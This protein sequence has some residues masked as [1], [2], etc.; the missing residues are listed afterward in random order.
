MTELVAHR[1]VR[2]RAAPSPTGAA[3]VGNAYIALFNLAFA[4]RHGG[5]FVMRIE[6]TDRARSRKKYEERLYAGWRWLGLHWDEGPDVGGNVGPYRQSER[7]EIYHEHARQLMDAGHAY[8]SFI[9][10]EELAAW[11][12]KGQ[13]EGEP[14][15]YEA[16]R[17]ADPVMAQA[18]AKSG[19]VS[20][21]RMKSPREGTCVFTDAFRGEIR[22]GYDQVDDQVLLKS[23]GFPTYH[24]AVV[25]DDHLMGITHVIRGEDWIP[26]TPKHMLL[27]EHFG[28]EA[29][30]HAH[31]PL[32]LNP[33][34]TKMSKRRNP[35]SIDY[36]RR[37][38]YLPQTML[39]YMA[40]MAYPPAPSTNNAG[41]GEEKFSFDNFVERFELENVNLGGSVFDLDKLSWLN[42]RYLREE[43][44][45]KQLGE[46][47]RHWA[48]NDEYIGRILPLMQ[49]RME[50]LGDF[51]P[52]CSFFFARSVDPKIEDL[53]PKKREASEVAKV[54]QTAVWSL[55]C[56]EP[57]SRDAVEVA[58]RRI[59]EFWD[60]PI[61][62]VTRPM[63]SAVMGQPVGPPLYESIVLLEL[64]LTR[65]RLLA[66]MET[67]GGVSKKKAR[68]LEKDWNG[69]GSRRSG[70]S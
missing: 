49:S 41:D 39:N 44:S 65:T 11:R 20:V 8:Y 62:D 46:A 36:Y 35:T 31:L 23:D 2:V 28:W 9:T 37:A 43:L 14:A 60:W 38:G 40:L 61:R 66:A 15:P 42:G 24:L 13:R 19:E 10:P 63:Y 30:M 25:V 1:P 7:S 68:G 27:Y 6:D 29:P 53:V 57:W 48:L 5:H 64:D 59:A 33:D 54:L 45:E 47:L 3:H 18:R 69:S 70:V 21:I 4:R 26:S 67:L 17:D 12:D 56:V 50:T 32:L 55:E 58:L 52:H 22:I 34:G 16:E 51:M